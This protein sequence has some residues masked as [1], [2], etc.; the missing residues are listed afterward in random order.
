MRTTLDCLPCFMRQILA[1]ARLA[2][3][4]D[5][6]LQERVVREGAALLSA[7]D[8]GMSPPALAGKVTE[9]VRGL[10]GV[11]DLFV[12]VKRTA[13]KRVLELL[14]ELEQRVCASDHPLLTAL[15]IAIIGNY[16]DVGVAETFDW[17]GELA[18][19]AG[20][21][22]QATVE[23]FRDR[24]G[25]G[26]KVLVLGDNAGEIG[27][28]TLLVRE[29]TSLGADV[30]YAVRG[31]P[32]LND[33]TLDDARTV[34]MDKL[35]RVTTSGVD[36]PGTVIARCAPEFLDELHGADLVLSKGQGNFE[37]LYGEWED[38]FFAFK[39]KCRVVEDITGCVKGTSMFLHG[40]NGS[41]GRGDG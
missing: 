37:S 35:C 16:M 9:V 22:D 20:D 41:V 31:V 6:S 39:V 10:T 4:D 12:E 21:L 33:A 24:I 30:A 29:L 36:T 25:A 11:G 13:N 28:D 34:G 14:P 2:A 15:E 7:A 23:E 8:L 32:V 27:L 3:P 5:K 1:G 26:T 40:R 18:Q 38:V 17:E 19:L